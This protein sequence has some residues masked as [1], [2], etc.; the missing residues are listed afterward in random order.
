MAQA[1]STPTAQP[2]TPYQKWLNEDVAYIT[3]DAERQAF[4]RLET[5]AEREHFIEQFWLRRDPTPG[6]PRNEFKEEHYRRI[7]YANARFRTA[8]ELP[9]WKTDRGR[10]YITFARLAKST[11]IRTA[12][13][14]AGI[15]PAMP[16][17]RGI[18]ATS[19]ESA[20]TC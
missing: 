3:T 8:T 1:Q 20:M 2:E 14:S 17:K 18:T 4:R 11:V 9:G 7:A 10:I 19:R 16:L 5:D 12:A 6:T 13:H 15:M